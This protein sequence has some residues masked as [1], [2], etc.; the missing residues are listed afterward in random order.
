MQAEAVIEKPGK[1]KNAR[2][3][4]GSLRPRRRQTGI[5][6]HLAPGFVLCARPNSPSARPFLNFLLP[7]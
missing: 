4:T 5:A 1:R 7:A 3:L 6:P 2:W